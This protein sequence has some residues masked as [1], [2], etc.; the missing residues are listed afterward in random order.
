M[1]ILWVQFEMFAF[2]THSIDIV[3]VPW[4]CVK[5][6]FMHSLMIQMIQTIENNLSK[7]RIE[8]LSFGFWVQ[9]AINIIVQMWTIEC[10]THTIHLEWTNGDRSFFLLLH[11]RNWLGACS[12]SHIHVESKLDSN[13]QRWFVLIQKRQSMK[14]FDI[15]IGFFLT[16]SLAEFPFLSFSFYF[17]GVWIIQYTCNFS[18]ISSLLDFV[19]YHIA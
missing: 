9:H 6:N 2:Q 14:M 8:A 3:C 15:N 10:D 5:F 16:L 11:K 13:E 12:I 18:D 4:F 17:F 19:L 1:G 7:D